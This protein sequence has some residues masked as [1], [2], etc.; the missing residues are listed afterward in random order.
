ML[1][2]SKPEAFVQSPGPYIRKYTRAG[3]N[4]DSAQMR[5]VD[6]PLEAKATNDAITVTGN[7]RCSKRKS[8]DIAHNI[9]VDQLND[10]P[11]PG[12]GGNH[13]GSSGVRN[14]SPE[15]PGSLVLP[16]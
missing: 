4:L 1:I 16:A 14:S 7:R 5:G 6:L 8:G 10:L 15:W 9:T 11:I 2:P 3:L 12:I 13:A